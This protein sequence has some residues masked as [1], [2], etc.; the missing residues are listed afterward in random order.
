M[1][2]LKRFVEFFKTP[3]HTRTVTALAILI[4]AAAVPLT[5]LVAQQQ[6]N[7]QQHAST[8]TPGFQ[9]CGGSLPRG[10]QQCNSSGTAYNQYQC[11]VDYH[12]AATV[13]GSAGDV[14]CYIDKTPTPAPTATPVST[15]VSTPVINPSS[16]T[17]NPTT[18]QGIP[19]GTSYAQ[20]CTNGNCSS[21]T[22]GGQCVVFSTFSWTKP[23]DASS[24]PQYLIKYQITTDYNTYGPYTSGSSTSITTP[25]KAGTTNNGF[26]FNQCSGLT[27]GYSCGFREGQTVTWYMTYVNTSG[28]RVQVNGQPFT[29]ASCASTPAP[30]ST[31]IGQT[32]SP[33]PT[34]SPSN[35]VATNL[36]QQTYCGVGYPANTAG[37]DANVSSTYFTW[38]RPTDGSGVYIKYYDVTANQWWGPYQYGSGTANSFYSPRQ[39]G[40]TT[41]KNPSNGATYNFTQCTDPLQSGTGYSC[42]FNQ[43]HQFQWYVYTLG[44]N[45]QSAQG[46]FTAATCPSPTPSPT[47]TPDCNGSSQGVGIADCSQAV[48]QPSQVN[49]CGAASGTETCVYN[50][51][52]VNS[53]QCNPVNVYNQSC[54]ASCA[55]GVACYN[56]SCQ[57]PTPTPTSSPAPTASPAPG[58]T[59]LALKV[60]MDA[61]G[62]VGDNENPNPSSSNQNPVH[63]NR[64]VEVWVFD[65]NNNQV[66][67]KL[68]S[69]N[70]NAGT[71]IFTGTVDL[72]GNF[73]T[74][75]YTIKVKS[76]GH[77]RRLIPGIQNIAAGQT[78][79]MPQVNLVAGDVNGDNVLNI[80]DYNILLSCINDPD[81]ANVDNHQ[82]CNSNP[83]YIINSDLDDN[84]VVNKF[85]YNL[86]VREYSV[87]SGD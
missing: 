31:P 51:Y 4:I 18:P 83:S 73:V 55:N 64:N 17:P 28:A 20:Y 53:S 86:F 37:N 61:I 67:D 85:D 29:T 13:G 84:G 44:T 1:N 3:G 12:C 14:S 33:S 5:V 69:I 80:T 50:T 43:G 49:A 82:L 52:N 87:Q 81:V 54:N 34:A 6:Q 48:C 75:N 72:G 21:S 79:Q 22:S 38:T 59:L 8:C 70:Y 32:P 63:P 77:L 60:G 36:N 10:Y 40:D 39:A 9:T 42:G 47:P 74:G 65:S 56:G 11:P 66:V 19:T 23:S 68:G 7:T 16:P 30:T 57:V 15:P 27:T 45:A 76:D 71:G 35:S 62:S 41:V 46:T 26:N 2:P 78:A 25:F 58:D 24:N